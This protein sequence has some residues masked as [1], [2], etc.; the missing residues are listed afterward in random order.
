VGHS[1][2]GAV[3][4]LATLWV[5]EKRLRLSSPFCVTFGCPLVGD[6]R[7]G[8]AIDRENWAGNF[9]HV[10]SKH[11]I[12]P[13]MLLAPFERIA[14]PLIVILPYWQGIMDADSKNVPDSFIQYA[15]RNLLNN[16]LQYTVANSGLD[17]PRELYMVAERSPYKP[18]G[19][20]MF[21]SNEVVACVAN[22]ETVLKLLHLTMQ[23]HEKLS[24]KIVQDSFSEHIGYRSVLEHVVKKSISRGKIAISNSESSYEM[25]ILLQL[26]DIGV[27]AQDDHAQFALRRAVETENKHNTNV[28]KLAHELSHAQCSMAELEWYKERCEKE[29]DIV[30]YD[31]FKNQNNKKDFRANVHRKKLLQFWDEIIEMWMRHELPS[32][33]QSQNKWINAG[34]TYRRLV[35][36]LD[37]TYYYCN[38]KS[39]YLSYGRPDRHKVLQKWMEEKEKTRSSKG[40]NPRTK[41]ASLTP[42]SCFWAHVEQALKDLENLKQDQ[43]Q[44]PENLEMF[45]G[46]VTKMINNR[47]ISSYV[48]LEASSFMIWWKEWKEYK[49]NQFA[50]WSSPLCKVM[51]SESWKG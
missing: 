21:C 34:T 49:Q 32:D 40:Q 18:Y 28:V 51:E 4:T 46:Y 20:Y 48:F 30:Y 27:G 17:F 23:S 43:H 38:G 31:S 3:A 33:F 50:E 42:D 1:L 36:P 16:V 7:L 15:C 25:G 37:I 35:E 5:L 8:E 10:V 13:R 14:E 29:D 22:S 39:D 9:C 45:E 12:V 24:D 44:N 19:T 11:D 47:N 2:G 6:V 26:E 41:F